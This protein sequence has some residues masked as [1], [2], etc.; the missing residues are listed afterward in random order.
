MLSLIAT[1]QRRFEA[2][3]SARSKSLSNQNHA[4]KVLAIGQE[5]VTLTWNANYQTTH[6][7][8]SPDVLDQL[9]PPDAFC[10]MCGCQLKADASGRHFWTRTC[11]NRL[12]AFYTIRDKAGGT[13]TADVHH[14]IEKAHV[15]FTSAVSAFGSPWIPYA[16]RLSTTRRYVFLAPACCCGD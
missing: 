6:A 7:D 15:R 11:A 9:V 4:E 3:G 1:K 12:A 5:T 16:A 10:F 8:I 13:E 14:G 2:K